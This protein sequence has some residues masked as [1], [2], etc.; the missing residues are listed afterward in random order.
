MQIVRRLLVKYNDLFDKILN[1]KVRMT[2][3]DT[4]KKPKSKCALA[5]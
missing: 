3:S 2:D 1:K 5:D 4:K